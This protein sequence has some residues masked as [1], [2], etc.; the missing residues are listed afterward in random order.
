MMLTDPDAD[1]AAAHET[2]DDQAGS[3]EEEEENEECEEAE[4]DGEE[5]SDDMQVTQFVL[6]RRRRFPDAK[7]KPGR[8]CDIAFDA[9][10]R[11]MDLSA[12][13][14]RKILKEAEVGPTS[15]PSH[16]PASKRRRIRE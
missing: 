13:Q 10:K 1:V 9:R 5:E 7:N 8:P 6:A 14:V 16:T 11:G 4:D 15:P 12:R 2:E 3:A